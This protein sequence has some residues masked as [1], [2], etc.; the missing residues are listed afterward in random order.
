MSLNKEGKS[1]Y[2]KLT[3]GLRRTEMGIHSSLP[4]EVTDRIWS[5]TVLAG[6]ALTSLLQNKKPKD[7]D[8]FCQT[9]GDLKRLLAKVYLLIPGPR[10]IV[11]DNAVTIRRLYL[12]D[13]QVIRTS[14]GSPT[15]II[16]R[17]DWVHC[18]AFY[19]F[20]RSEFGCHPGFRECAEGKILRQNSL[21]EGPINPAR[22]G[23]FLK[24]G[25]TIEDPKAEGLR[26]LKELTHEEM[27]QYYQDS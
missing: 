9:E 11:T 19:Q 13:I 24:R 4:L 12:P 21:L 2:L 17:F 6:G 26:L 22:L 7:L 1:T 5:T 25:Y 15:E 23:K 8:L 27:Y 16:N 18:M 20:E 14:V 10:L 3:K